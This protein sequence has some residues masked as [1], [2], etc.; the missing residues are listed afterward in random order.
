MYNLIYSCVDFEL[1]A[2]Q[3]RMQVQNILNAMTKQP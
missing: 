1:S 2:L 3:L